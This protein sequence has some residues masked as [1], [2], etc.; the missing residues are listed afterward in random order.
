MSCLN[1]DNL[2]AKEKRC[3]L[4][5]VVSLSVEGEDRPPLV[6]NWV[7]GMESSNWSPDLRGLSSFEMEPGTSPCSA[8]KANKRVLKLILYF[9][10]NQR[11]KANTGEIW[12]L[13]LVPV[14][15]LAAAF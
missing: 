11:G 3:V 8:L 7:Q 4:G 9:T 1:D 5:W 6:F 10:G 2:E 12:C 15:S 14:R 13:L